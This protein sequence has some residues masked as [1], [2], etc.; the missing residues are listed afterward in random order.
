[1]GFFPAHHRWFCKIKILSMQFFSYLECRQG[2]KTSGNG[3]FIY[4]A[5]TSFNRTGKLEITGKFSTKQYSRLNNVLVTA[6]DG[7]GKTVF[8]F[9]VSNGK[10]TLL[11]FFSTHCESHAKKQDLV[12]NAFRVS[13][14]ETPPVVGYR[15]CPKRFHS[16]LVFA[17]TFVL[18]YYKS[19][20]HDLFLYA[21]GIIFPIR[22]FQPTRS[23]LSLSSFAFLG[24]LCLQYGIR[25]PFNQGKWTQ[26]VISPKRNKKF[27]PV[28]MNG[29]E[30]DT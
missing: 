15:P 22:I 14:Q 10:L 29:D 9:T 3:Y 17:T 24:S 2:W 13:S 26:T 23:P 19:S 12:M 8:Q 28:L 1:M 11:I 30:L 7:T 27:P 16:P 18:K 6:E 5:S 25:L 4:K 20:F 21:L